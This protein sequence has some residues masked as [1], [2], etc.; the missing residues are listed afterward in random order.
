[1]KGRDQGRLPLVVETQQRGYAFF[2]L[3]GGLVGEGNGQDRR[4]GHTFGGDEVSDAMRN[5]A[6]FTA[7]CAGKDEERA[8]GMTHRFSLLR[9]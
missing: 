6:G 7:A 2:H 9:V 1:M 4:S 5:D 8:F 3:P